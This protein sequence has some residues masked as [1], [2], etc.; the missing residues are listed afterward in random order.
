MQPQTSLDPLLPLAPPPPLLEPPLL[1]PA[2]LLPPEP[3]EPPVL[4]PALLLPPEPFPEL[5]PLLLE[6]LLELLLF[7]DVLALFLSFSAFLLAAS[8]SA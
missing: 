1:E 7:S 8:S 4:E 5:L 6:P 2:L 3:L